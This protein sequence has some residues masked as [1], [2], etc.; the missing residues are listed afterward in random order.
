MNAKALP[1]HQKRERLGTNNEITNTTYETIDAPTKKTYNRGTA[2][3]R[4]HY[5]NMPIQI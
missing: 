5:E 3:E 1:R 2:V 4:I